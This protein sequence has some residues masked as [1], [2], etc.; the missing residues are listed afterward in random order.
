M[1]FKIL[2]TGLMTTIKILIVFNTVFNSGG[3]LMNYVFINFHVY[4]FSLA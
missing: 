1:L 3:R 4:Y 2:K